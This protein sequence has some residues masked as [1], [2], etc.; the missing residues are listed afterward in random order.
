MYEKPQ[1]EIEVA[2]WGGVYSF[3]PSF[4]VLL[5]CPPYMYIFQPLSLHNI[6][7]QYLNIRN[8]QKTQK[9][10]EWPS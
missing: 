8:D 1:N 3:F 2:K 6:P 5:S 4:V 7:E 9:E 10:T